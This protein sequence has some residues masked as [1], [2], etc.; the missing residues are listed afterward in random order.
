MHFMLIWR[1]PH[2]IETT[3]EPGDKTRYW[4]CVILMHLVGMYL[5]N[6]MYYLYSQADVLFRS[7]AYWGSTT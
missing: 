4:C 2:K 6:T 5:H 1:K 3:G 7:F